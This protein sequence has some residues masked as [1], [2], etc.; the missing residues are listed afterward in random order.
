MMTNE[1]SQE[2]LS[3]LMVLASIA[4]PEYELHGLVC[5]VVL[6]SSASD[7]TQLATSVESLRPGLCESEPLVALCKKTKDQLND[8][9]L[10]FQL[11]LASDDSD[12]LNLRVE[13][14][15]EWVVAFLEGFDEQGS[16]TSEELEEILGDFREIA[17]VDSEVQNTD[18]M[19]RSFEELAEFVRIGVLYMNE[20]LQGDGN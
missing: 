4:L 14:L 17:L 20:L 3:D 5:G 12:A 9:N 2:Q 7:E 15:G 18:E 10:D 8:P 11:A 6:F 13:A 16:A 1:L 19:Q